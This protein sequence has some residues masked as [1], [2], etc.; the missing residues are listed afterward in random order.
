M[1]WWERIARRFA[2]L[3]LITAVIFWSIPSAF[4]GLISQIDYLATHLFFLVWIKQL[5]SVIVNFLQGFVPSIAL[6]LWMAAVP[7]MLRALGEQA[8]IPSRT[9]VELFVQKAY[10]AFQV[11]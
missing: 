9:M 6:S 3:S 7:I 10:F 8:G 4:I 1:P 2:A 5:P 11:V